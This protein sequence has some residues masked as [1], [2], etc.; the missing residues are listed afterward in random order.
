MSTTPLSSE[1]TSSTPSSPLQGCYL[2]CLDEPNFHA[3]HY[4]GYAD[5]IARRIRTHRL[6]QGSPLLAAATAAGIG[7]QVVQV[8][9]GADR[10]F[11]RKLHNRH[12]SRLCQRPRCVA[13]Q[14][15]RRLQLRLLS[16]GA[17]G[18]SF[19]DGRISQ[20]V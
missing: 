4:V 7:W 16:T 6:G 2:I 17:G 8:W 19:G 5:D 13:A 10:R 11:E 18:G 12:G 20:T 9:P 14:L 1:S 15:E 3:R